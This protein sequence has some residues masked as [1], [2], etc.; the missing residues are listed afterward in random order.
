[1]RSDLDTQKKSALWILLK[2]L[3]SFNLKITKRGSIYSRENIYLLKNGKGSHNYQ[4][5]KCG[6]LKIP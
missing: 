1:M 3:Q 2:T 5:P 6:Y 4:I